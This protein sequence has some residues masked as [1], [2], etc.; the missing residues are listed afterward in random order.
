MSTKIA[1][2]LGTTTIKTHYSDSEASVYLRADDVIGF[3]QN[4]SAKS[5]EM[6]KKLT[7]FQGAQAEAVAET[8]A[9][10]CE[11]FNTIKNFEL[12]RKSSGN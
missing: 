12:Q 4:A 10:F 2:P 6:S 9:V 7:P 8:L 3:L 5:H 11:T 1:I